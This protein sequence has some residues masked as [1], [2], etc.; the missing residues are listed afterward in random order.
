MQPTQPT[1]A[2]QPTPS[3]SG[4][5]P[6]SQVTLSAE[7]LTHLEACGI[8]PEQADDLIY[9]A[10]GRPPRQFTLL[11]LIIVLLARVA[12][13]DQFGANVPDIKG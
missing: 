3:A 4:K 12:E 9:S 8:T 1:P 13:L 6:R 10:C 5:L 2:E 11:T 7:E